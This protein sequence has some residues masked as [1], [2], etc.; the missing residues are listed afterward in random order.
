MKDE[1]GDFH[2]SSLLPKPRCGPAWKL[3]CRGGSGLSPRGD[4]T[5]LLSADG[6]LG[7]EA[8]DGLGED[9]YAVAVVRGGGGAGVDCDGGRGGVELQ[10]AE[11]K[12]VQR[13]L[14]LEQDQLA[15]RLPAGLEA[16]AHLGEVRVTDELPL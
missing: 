13:L 14:V 12:V 1:S 15:E 2:P 5:E 8:A 16:D 10:L 7:H 3:L 9:E 11:T 6:R 4:E